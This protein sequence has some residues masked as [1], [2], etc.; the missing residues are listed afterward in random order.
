MVF[1]GEMAEL[2]TGTEKR[3]HFETGSTRNG[4]RETDDAR[5]LY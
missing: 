4:G 1:G 5:E 3:E 2:S